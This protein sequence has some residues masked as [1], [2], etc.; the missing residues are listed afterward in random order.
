M[1]YAL[2]FILLIYL[3][4]R[5]DMMDSKVNKDFWY[6]VMLIIFILVAGLRYRLGEDTPNYIHSFYHLHPTLDKFSFEDYPIG[7]DPL[8]ALLNSIVKSLGGRFYHVQLIHATFINIL[9]FKYIKK[10]SS[11]IFTCLIFYAFCCYTNYNM[12]IMRGSL[13]VV[14]CLY[15]NDYIL[16]KK[17]VKG[18]LLFLVALLCHAQTILM[19]FLPLLFFIRLDLKGLLILIVSFFVGIIIQEQLGD[20]LFL[21][22]ASEDMAKKAQMYSELEEYGGQAGNFNFMLVRFIPDIVYT[23]VALWFVKQK[24]KISSL[25]FLEPLVMIGLV[26]LVLQI[27]LQIAYRF[28]DYYRIYFVMFFSELFIA[29]AK[30]NIK[31]PKETAY[32][33]MIAIFLPYF[34]LMSYWRAAVFEQYYPYSSVFD[35]EKSPKREI[36]YMKDDRWGPRSDEF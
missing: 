3:S 6:V 10:H 22:E 4:F 8:W 21:L 19:F 5:Y 23:L 24:N 29:F 28:V 15:A 36:L 13:S 2:I 11:Y 14:L 25:L 12:Q 35:M 34:S 27:N 9:L 7:K 26:F 30:K 33:V 20:Y 17:W 16:E 18:Y 31:M 32:V 1:L